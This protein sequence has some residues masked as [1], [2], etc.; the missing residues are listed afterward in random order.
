M[1]G[2]SRKPERESNMINVK[3]VCFAAA[4]AVGSIAQAHAMPSQILAAPAVSSSVVDIAACGPGTH[5]GPYRHYC[6]PNGHAYA[7]PCPPGFVLG[8]HHEY[9]WPVGYSV[10]PHYVGMCPPGYH[11]GPDGYRCWR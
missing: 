10:P 11:L 1:M 4:I 9:C 7:G 2:A 8:P 6:W 3:A 5:L